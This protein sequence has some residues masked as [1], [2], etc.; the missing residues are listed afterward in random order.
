MNSPIQCDTLE[1]RLLL[2]GILAGGSSVLFDFDADG[3][4]DAVLRNIG[5]VDIEYDQ[6]G[7]DGLAIGLTADGAKF[8]TNTWVE[9]ADADPA[10]DFDLAYAKIGTDL[11]YDGENFDA[12]F[13]TSS[14]TAGSVD[15]LYIGEGD[16]G[17]AETTE[18]G[19]N[20]AVL[21]DGDI[22]GYVA[23]IGDIGEIVADAIRGA[24]MTTDGDYDGVYAN[25]GEIVVDEI[26]DGAFIEAN[27]INEVIAATIDG[28][29]Q[30]MAYGYIEKICSDL[31]TGQAMV[32]AYGGLGRL[33]ADVIED[34]LITVAGDT[35]MI[36]VDRLAGSLN[37]TFI[38]LDGNLDRLQADT[39]TGGTDYAGLYVSVTGSVERI[40]ANTIT[41]GVNSSVY[42]AID[43]DLGRLNVGLFEGGDAADYGFASADLTVIGRIGK[44]CAGLIN[45]G[46]GNGYA[47]LT[48]NAADIGYLR[49]AAITGGNME[50]G[51]DAM[52]QFDVANDLTQARIGQLIGSGTAQPIGDPSVIFNVGNDFGELVVGEMT[53]GTAT[54]E[55]A[56]ASIEMNVGNNFGK[57]VAERIDAGLADGDYATADIYITVGWD[58]GLISA[59]TISGGV[60]D[61]EGA[62]AGVYFDAGNNIDVI[63]VGE[64]SGTQSRR[65]V[66][67][68]DPT[69]KFLAG[70][71]IGLVMAGRIIG[72]RIVADG[73]AIAQAAVT[74]H[75]GNN[76]DKIVAGTIT[77]GSAE[78]EN[79]LAYV[80]I[81]AGNNIGK[82]YADRISGG[83]SEDGGY[84]YVNILAEHDIEVMRVGTIIGSEN[85]QGCGDPGVQIQAYND[86][87]DFCA[88]RIIAGED[89][90]VNILAGIDGDGNISGDDGEAGSIERMVVGMIDGDDGMINIAAG[91]D[92]EMLKVCRVVSGDD[93]DVNIIAG[94]DMTVDVRRV[95][96]WTIEDPDTGEVIDSGV[97]F[98]AGGEVND[99]RN[100]IRDEYITEGAAEMPELMDTPEA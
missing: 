30:V 57:I 9:V 25:I 39:I 13:G 63:A 66:R 61:G 45:G 24:Y 15:R 36:C 60:A 23:S 52:V 22:T 80:K 93:G 95:R 59:G 50:D 78:G 86:I 67:T 90:I 97:S 32:D 54:G 7:A 56:Y 64:I 42:L 94:G 11:C 87:K 19:I 34:A 47:M 12:I 89:G 79:A 65:R 6:A 92:I 51:G 55:Y 1:P 70:N 69:V 91:G 33:S 38:S 53:A 68:P 37:G 43:Q 16:L 26:T 85:G 82:I 75:A 29:S 88:G 2:S 14:L 27:S 58:I 62:M 18:G 83:E 35:D 21:F 17:L 31:I 76:I 5:A 74:L 20:R 98:T 44:I 3:V 48:V 77:G 72:G 8:K 100:R 99:R 81:H 4:N 40:S 41:G 49:A 96:S 84:A 28:A 73:D 10:D 71:D 46:I